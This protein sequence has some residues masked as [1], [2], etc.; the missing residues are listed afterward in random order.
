MKHY[1]LCWALAVAACG[2]QQTDRSGLTAATLEGETVGLDCRTLAS[3]DTSAV[4]QAELALI[5]DGERIPV[6]TISICQVIPTDAYA[7]Y[8]IPAGALVAA[9]GWWAGTGDY[10]YLSR[11][12]N[13]VLLMHGWMDEAQA[14]PRFTYA[15]VREVRL[16]QQ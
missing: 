8:D 15:A 5:I 2:C 10:F 14:T 13:T 6:D 12:G 11:Q 16:R 7:S 9:G 4:P 3:S 1:L